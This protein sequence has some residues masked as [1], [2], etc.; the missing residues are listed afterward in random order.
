MEVGYAPQLFPSLPSKQDLSTA[1]L[2]TLKS[3]PEIVTETRQSQEWD[4]SYPF[5]HLVQI[6]L[7]VVL[8]VGRMKGWF[9]SGLSC[10]FRCMS[11]YWATTAVVIVAGKVCL[12]RLKSAS[13]SL[14]RSRVFV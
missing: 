10:T 11:C 4:L 3:S 8:R 1:I 6:S 5:A 13:E 7:L 12:W 9:I 14:R 2:M